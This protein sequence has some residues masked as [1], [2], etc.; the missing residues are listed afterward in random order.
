M[1]FLTLW[2]EPLKRGEDSPRLAT[3][4]SNYLGKLSPA[5]VGTHAA[6]GAVVI[7]VRGIGE[8]EAGRIEGAI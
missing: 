4:A 8:F 1:D 3:D 2:C 7:E 6:S 5:E